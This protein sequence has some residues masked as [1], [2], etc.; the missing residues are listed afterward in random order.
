MCLSPWIL[1]IRV[2]DMN[3]SLC[4]K[5]SALITRL[6]D[7]RW[8]DGFGYLPGV[9][10]GGDIHIHLLPLLSTC[11]LPEITTFRVTTW[12]KK[13]KAGFVIEQCNIFP[14]NM[15]K[16]CQKSA[17]Q[18]KSKFKM[19]MSIYYPK[20]RWPSGT[21]NKRKSMRRKLL[22]YSNIVTWLQKA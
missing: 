10:A 22:K 14:Y 16:W 6:L 12:V 20:N 17:T 1:R 21:C 15:H 5:A 2:V 11:V 19:G 8:G 18:I 7:C 13:K 9:L 3:L 4:L